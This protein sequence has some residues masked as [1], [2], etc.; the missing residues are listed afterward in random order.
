MPRMKYDDGVVRR[1]SRLHSWLPPPITNSSRHDGLAG[2]VGPVGAR[3]VDAVVEQRVV[4]VLG[5]RV[6]SALH[7]GAGVD[8]VEVTHL[9][10]D[11]RGDLVPGVPRAI[12]PKGIDLQVTGLRIVAKES[13]RLHLLPHGSRAHGPVRADVELEGGAPTAGI[14]GL[15]LLFAQ[16]RR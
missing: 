4:A 5:N 7:E 16:E 14:D 10:F 11:G 8:E 12:C 9:A 2:G 1:S 15:K 3:A 6:V 13:F